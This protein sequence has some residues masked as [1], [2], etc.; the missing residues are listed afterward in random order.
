MASTNIQSFPGKVGVSNTNPIHTLDIGSNVY[1][2]DTSDTKIRV[3]G[4]IHASGVIVDGSITVIETDNLS[5]KDPVLLLA[6]GSTGTSDTG[7]IMKRAD[8]DANVA[9]FYDEGVGLNVC[10][11]LS[12][13][14][15]IH[16]SV[17]GSNALATSIYGPVHVVNTGTEALVVDGGSKIDGNLQ[18]GTVGDLFVDTVTSNVGVG[19][20]SPAY[21]LDVHGTS[22]VGALTATSITASTVSAVTVNSNVVS[23]NVVA[24]SGFYGAIEGSN[25]I[26]GSTGTFSSNLEVGTA[27]LFV[28]TVTSNVGIGT[29][30][31]AYKLDVHGSANVAALTATLTYSNASANIVA[32]NSSTNEV[33]DSGIERGFTEHPVAPMT[34]YTTYVEGHG[35]YE[36]SASGTYYNGADYRFP[37]KAFDYGAAQ[38]GV[39]HWLSFQ[40]TY[41]GSSPYNHIGSTT[42]VDV[43][44][45]RYNGEYL[46]LKLPYSITLSHCTLTSI[47]N[48]SPVD[49]YIFGSSDGENWYKLTTFTGRAVNGSITVNATTQYT[50]FRILITKIDGTAGS[51]LI[52]EWRLFAEKSVTRMEN[53]HISGA[54]SSETLHT[55]HIK[56]PKVPLKGAESEGYV[57]SASSEYNSVYQAFY[58]FDDQSTIL[59]QE[60]TYAWVTPVGTFDTTTGNADSA[61]CATFDNLSC[62]W[63]QLQSPNPFAVSYFDFYRRD[64]T[65]YDSIVA[66]ETPR[67][68]YLYASNDG[69]TWTRLTYFSNLPKLG[70][71]DLE[72][73]NIGSNEAYTYYRL[74]VTKVHPGGIGAYLG[75][76]NLRFFESTVGV[77]TS[78]TTAKLT[79]E[80]GLGLAKGS[81][82]FA[83]SDVVMELPRHERP[84]TKYPEI[85][86]SGVGAV[87]T[88]TQGGYTLTS[89]ALYTGNSSY[90][91]SNAFDG[92]LTTTSSAWVSKYGGFTN[93]TNDGSSYVT[94]ATSSDQ[95]NPGTGAVHINGPWLKV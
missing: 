9:I 6:S 78:A 28:D 52:E 18:V 25:T 1:I 85:K 11:T 69:V 29:D 73:V 95:F 7:I 33:I 57:A 84:L 55:S 59:P 61:N 13:G 56:W 88:T 35:T 58:A 47:A 20:N 37:W 66:Q 76:S 60:I 93:P 70:P 64:T 87:T 39:G 21:K 8:G 12:R 68:G 19:T 26:A 50:H 67:E 72:R 27:N 80:G 71:H 4:N 83:G 17:D 40:G 24:T 32:W 31:P 46:T 79:V 34:D 81:Q 2:D 63:I 86:F 5:V 90:A 77:G 16:L 75:I 94:P 91:L 43:G 49:G 30:T 36:A 51:A 15:E 48:Y 44:G 89:S 38:N 62:E 42:L 74:V 23:D 3:Y 22:N 53:V 92:N 82:V 45:T 65:D 10:H 14:D 54:L 41:S